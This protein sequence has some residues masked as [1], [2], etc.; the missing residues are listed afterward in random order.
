MPIDLNILLQPIS[1]AQPCGPELI[2]SDLFLIKFKIKSGEKWGT[3]QEECLKVLKS[4]RHL[5]ATVFLIASLVETDGLEG[6]RD[7]LRLLHG[8]V[9]KYWEG[10][11]PLMGDDQDPSERCNII[12]SL[13]LESHGDELQFLSRVRRLPLIHANSAR[14]SIR[15]V[16]VA[17]GQWPSPS[18]DGPTL[19]DIEAGC[20][21]AS[22]DQMRADSL[23][24]SEC[25]E[26]VEQI[27]QLI[28]DKTNM[29]GPDFKPLQYLVKQMKAYVDNALIARGY[30]AG[31]DAGGQ[32]SSS[33][34]LVAS[35]V[36]GQSK[37]VAGGVVVQSKVVGEVQ[38]PED[39]VNL[40]K[41]ICAYYSQNEPSSPIPLLLKR[42]QSLVN[43]PFME[44]VQ[45][46]A[47]DAVRQIE[48]ISGSSEKQ[49]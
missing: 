6:L 41:T 23:V 48:I 38:S 4:C 19:A 22:S 28:D 20:K 10:I 35:G 2:G 9:D 16:F 36:L 25:A 12:S 46:L 18:V 17:S 11:H 43:K 27:S 45:D 1:E 21:A 47:P 32:E 31:E 33:S 5:E 15:D 13:V 29:R 39:V 26:L 24:L 40:L 8:L 7:G 30:L 42:A 34:V 49:A 3:I 37:V 14:Y 44:I